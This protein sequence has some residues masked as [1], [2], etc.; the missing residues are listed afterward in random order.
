MKPYRLFEHRVGVSRDDSMDLGDITATGAPSRHSNRNT[1]KA[2]R[3]KRAMRRMVKR[4]GRRA[5]AVAAV[6]EV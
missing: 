5:S 2:A 6:D 1:P 4:G 3:E